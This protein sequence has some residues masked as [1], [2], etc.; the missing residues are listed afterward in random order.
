M[1]LEDSL[2]YLQEPPLVTIMS[3]VN[4]THIL[5]TYYFKIRFNIILPFTPTSPKWSLVLN[6][7]S[8]HEY[9]ILHQYHPDHMQ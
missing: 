1:G 7:S 2:T 8:P 9:F 6:N 4:P 3:Q 5:I